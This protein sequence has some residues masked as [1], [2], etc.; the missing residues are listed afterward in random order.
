MEKPIV[1]IIPI[2]MGVLLYGEHET[3]VKTYLELWYLYSTFLE[4]LL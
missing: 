3:K 4:S 2:L 1:Y